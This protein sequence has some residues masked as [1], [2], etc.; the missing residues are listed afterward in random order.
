[1]MKF[2]RFKVSTVQLLPIICAVIVLP[3]TLP[4]AVRHN[5]GERSL[6]S[7]HRRRCRVGLGW[8]QL[9]PRS[10]HHPQWNPLEQLSRVSSASVWSLQP[11]R[12]NQLRRATGYFR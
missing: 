12:S 9:Q 7:N 1:M 6:E 11:P 10:V 2:L 8:P 5:Y 4:K 3:R